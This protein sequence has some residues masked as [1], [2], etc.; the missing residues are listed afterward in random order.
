MQARFRDSKGRPELIHTLNGSG[1]AVGRTLVAILEN[2][3][4]PDGSVT[5]PEV[6]RHY[7][8]EMK[9]LAKE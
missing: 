1:L 4:N 2:Y 9:Q 7:M 5:I 6:L 8:G 3:Q